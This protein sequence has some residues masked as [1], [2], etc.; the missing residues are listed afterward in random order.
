MQLGSEFT[1]PLAGIKDQLV[2]ER[3]QGGVGLVTILRLVQRVLESGDLVAVD[4]GKVWVDPRESAIGCVREITLQLLALSLEFKQPLLGRRSKDPLL[5]GGDSC[6][7][8]C[9]TS[10]RS[11]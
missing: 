10:A 6:L 3:A 9:S 4:L 2:D 5:N 1:A 7:R 11:R 8:R